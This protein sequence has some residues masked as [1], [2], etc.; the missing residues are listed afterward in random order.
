LKT[1]DI[2]NERISKEQVVGCLRTRGLLWRE[3]STEAHFA[4]AAGVVFLG[5]NPS[6][7]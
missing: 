4:L 5:K 7:S 6:A 1:G 2:A 3:R